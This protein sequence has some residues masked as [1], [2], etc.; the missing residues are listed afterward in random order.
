MNEI[1]SAVSEGFKSVEKNLS[2]KQAAFES[3]MNA[4]IVDIAQSKTSMGGGMAAEAKSVNYGEEVERQFKSFEANFDK[5]PNIKIELKAAPSFLSS[6]NGASV[7]GN[8][9]GSGSEPIIGFQNA[10]TSSDS[11]HANSLVYSRFISGDTIVGSVQQVKEGDL[12]AQLNVDLLS[13]QQDSIQIATWSKASRQIYKDTN[14]GISSLLNTAHRRALMLQ[15]DDIL[16]NGTKLQT[17]ANSFAGYKNLFTA[18]TNK[19]TSVIDNISNA[20][21]WLQQKGFSADTVVMSANTALEIRVARDKND[22]PLG[23]Y[24]NNTQGETLRGLR[25][26]ISPAFK[27]TEVAVLSSAHSTLNYV[28]ALSTQIFIAGDDAITNL[29]TFLTETRVIPTFLSANSGLVFTTTP[30]SK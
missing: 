14:G 20:Q 23:E 16:W 11:V 1:Q 4:A 28:D 10:I 21:A 5:T 29:Q 22:R 13:V 9:Y 2:E 3:K 26:V 18:G 30:A 12:K 8:V 19:Y 17:G 6:A 27:D 7:Q 25:I 24:L 15:L